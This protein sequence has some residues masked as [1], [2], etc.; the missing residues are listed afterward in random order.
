MGS[1]VFTVRMFSTWVR[2]LVAAAGGDAAVANRLNLSTTR[3]AQFKDPDDR[4][5]PDILKM[6]QLMEFAEAAGLDFL[7][8]LNDCF[9]ANAAAKEQAKEVA[10]AIKVLTGAYRNKGLDQL[11]R[12]TDLAEQALED[13]DE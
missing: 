6:A 3:I 2:T 9:G 8:M 10:T 13:A 5:L 11:Q 4:S 12:L 7:H 1:E